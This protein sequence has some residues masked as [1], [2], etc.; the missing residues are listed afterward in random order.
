MAI[1]VAMLDRSPRRLAQGGVISGEIDKGF[2]DRT[3]SD[4]NYD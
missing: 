4:D 1:G 2:T 3:E